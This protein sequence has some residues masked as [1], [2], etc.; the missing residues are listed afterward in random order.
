MTSGLLTR[1]KVDLPHFFRGYVLVIERN[2]TCDAKRAPQNV[3]DARRKPD[4]FVNSRLQTRFNRNY[5]Q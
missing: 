4:R 3:G 5:S 2:A 1:F